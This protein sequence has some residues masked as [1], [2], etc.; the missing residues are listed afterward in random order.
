MAFKNQKEEILKFYETTHEVVDQHKQTYGKLV[1]K[2]NEKWGL[3]QSLT[4]NLDSFM[5]HSFPE[6]TAFKQKIGDQPL[7]NDA[8]THVFDLNK[9]EYVT[10]F[11]LP[12][13]K[14]IVKQRFSCVLLEQRLIIGTLYNGQP[15]NITDISKET[16][17]YTSRNYMSNKKTILESNGI[18][19]IKKPCNCNSICN[20]NRNT[21]TIPQSIISDMFQHSQYYKKK[22]TKDVEIWIDDYFNIFIPK[23]KTYLVFNFSKYPLYAFFLNMDKLNLYHNHIEGSIRSLMFNEECPSDLAT[24]N[25][26][27]SFVDVDGDYLTSQ[28]K[29]NHY[30][31][32]FPH[33]L[34]FYH[35]HDKQA[36]FSHYQTLAEK[37][38]QV[39]PSAYVDVVVE[40][41]MNDEHK[42]FTQSQRIR[43][44]E[45]THQKQL[46]EIDFLRN[47]RSQY[48]EKEHIS[49]T[50]LTDYQNLLEELNTQL[51]T[52]IDNYSNQQK[53]IIKLKNINLEYSHIK[54]K[55]RRL[56]DSIDIIKTKLHETENSLSK[57][58]TVNNTLIDKQLESQQKL[59]LER[60]NSK[61]HL[62]TIT[63][64]KLE[65]QSY[66]ATIKKLET[67]ITCS[68]ETHSISK[69]KID[70]LINSMSNRETLVEDN[71]Q[72]ILLAQ[73]KE[74]NYEIKEIQLHNSKLAKEIETGKTEFSRLKSQVSALLTK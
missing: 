6:F 28:D 67:A 59:V 3:T 57:L 23:L 64:L 36:F 35:Y 51:H 68:K 72:E 9:K 16:T 42:I 49:T 13:K 21:N 5:E 33:V 69:R 61:E 43:E 62:E 34:N 48:I 26:V 10:N 8:I 27:K 65:I 41:T 39:A 45:V 56:E 12:N 55:Y 38:D 46:E 70:E 18:I 58:K 63:Q 2:L 30:K 17:S 20:C 25:L 22:E 73:L 15:W 31:T 44:L 52:E 53:E 47:E 19:S 50:T 29:R 40:D 74:K 14:I 71:Y 11:T 54:T 37:L 32:L 4:T 66:N 24:Y 7:E 1:N 60:T